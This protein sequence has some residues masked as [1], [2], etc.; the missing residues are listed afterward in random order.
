MDKKVPALLVSADG[1]GAP[2]ERGQLMRRQLMERGYSVEEYG[3]VKKLIILLHGRNGRK[4]DLLPVAERMCAVGFA[5]VIPD[6]PAH[7]ESVIGTVGCGERII[8]QELP[9]RVADE[10]L[11][12]LGIPGLPTCLWGMS[13]G[14]SF[15][16]H[17]AALEPERWERMVIVSSFDTLGG[18]IDDSRVGWFRPMLET[19]IEM[20][21]GPNVSKVSPVTL[22]AGLELP[23]LFVHGDADELIGEQ[24]GRALFDAC[25]GD[26]KFMTVEGGTHSNVLVT[27]APVYAEMAVWL[28]GP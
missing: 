15:A 21:G 7:G 1:A 20:R 10:A 2:A 28:L 9:G 3:V 26:K 19:M 12:K 18:V 4:E 16:V 14:G 5:C 23:T 11:L 17:A 8:E 25:A 27:E 6:L 13:M 24:R 22:M